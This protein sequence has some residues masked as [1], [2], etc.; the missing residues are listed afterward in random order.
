M[1]VLQ[2][3]PTDGAEL[4]VSYLTWDELRASRESAM[5]TCELVRDRYAA[6]G[7]FPHVREKV[8]WIDPSRPAEGPIRF[9]R[10]H[11]SFGPRWYRRPAAYVALAVASVSTLVWNAL[12]R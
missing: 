2:R 11:R 1:V 4:V 12:R 6:N 10:L 7:A 5:E 9:W 8:T 3:Q